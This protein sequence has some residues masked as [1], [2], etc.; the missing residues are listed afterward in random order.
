MSDSEKLEFFSK[1]KFDVNG[2]IPAIIQDASTL[3]VLTV[4]FMNRDTIELS[5]AKRETYFWSRSRQ[6]IWHKGATSGNT[7]KIV[8]IKA[9]C[10][11]DALLVLVNPQGPACHTGAQSCF[12]QSIFSE[13]S[14]G[15]SQLPQFSKT[16]DQLVKTIKNRKQHKPEGSYTSYLF[17][18]GRDKILKKIGEES[19]ET[20]IAAK[21]LSKRELTS[22]SA[23]LFYHLLVLLINEGV[24]IGEVIAELDRRAKKRSPEK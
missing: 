7:Q 8:T 14:S 17:T 6:E 12:Y 23:D 15:N 22:E 24:E 11:G 4:A 1:L 19:A 21:N 5:L 10:D 16:V 20:I 2:L 18:Q 13:T 9:D 3:E